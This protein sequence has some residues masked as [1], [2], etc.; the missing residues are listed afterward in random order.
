MEGDEDCISSILRISEVGLC[1]YSPRTLMANQKTRL[2]LPLRNW[3]N[4]IQQ[5]ESL[6]IEGSLDQME[7]DLLTK[8]ENAITIGFDPKRSPYYGSCFENH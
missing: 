8:S 5:S 3:N 4:A 7:F 6:L 1:Q 2:N